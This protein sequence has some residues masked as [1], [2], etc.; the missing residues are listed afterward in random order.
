MRTEL[1]STA[2]PLPSQTEQ[3]SVNIQQLW[4][5]PLQKLRVAQWRAETIAECPRKR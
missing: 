1:D 3:K 5:F 4:Q 2:R